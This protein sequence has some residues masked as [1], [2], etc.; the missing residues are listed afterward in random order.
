MRCNASDGHIFTSSQLGEGVT[1]S[2]HMETHTLSHWPLLLSAV[3]LHRD[4]ENRPLPHRV[5][6]ERCCS[7]LLRSH[8]LRQI[9]WTPEY[10]SASLDRKRRASAHSHVGDDAESWRCQWLNSSQTSWDVTYCGTVIDRWLQLTIYLHEW[11]SPGSTQRLPRFPQISR[12][13]RLCKV[14]EVYSFRE[15]HQKRT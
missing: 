10:W 7:R 15:L 1:T 6:W 14:V 8:L 3:R 5:Q 4:T 12:T 13:K 2:H 9:S 11:C